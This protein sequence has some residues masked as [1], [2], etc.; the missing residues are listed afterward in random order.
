MNVV[1]LYYFLG[2]IFCS[3]ILIAE[4]FLLS[5]INGQ[6]GQ[7][8]QLKAK[9]LEIDQQR[10]DIQQLRQNNTQLLQHIKF[11]DS[12]SAARID[13]LQE[14]IKSHRNQLRYSLDSYFKNR[15]DYAPI[16]NA[17]DSDAMQFFGL[18]RSDR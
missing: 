9:A 6:Q 14:D 15:Q 5:R 10:N 7:L 17:S 3:A 13:S 8:E 4:L 11:R 12:I 2:S 18:K 16:Y 1:R